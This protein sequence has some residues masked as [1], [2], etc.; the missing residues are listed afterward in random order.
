MS[1][2]TKSRNK[3]SNFDGFF[4]SLNTSDH[5]IYGCTTTALVVGQ[6]KGFYILNG[7]HLEKYKQANSDGGISSC[8]QYFKDNLSLINKNSEKIQDLL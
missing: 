1:T 5:H 2:T 7:D 6:M 3:I 8:V 4:V